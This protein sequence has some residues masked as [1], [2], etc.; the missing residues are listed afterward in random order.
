MA[1]GLP[2]HPSWREPYLKTSAAGVL[3]VQ[4]RT[5]SA[6]VRPVAGRTPKG[7][8]QPEVGWERGGEG[9]DAH[10]APAVDLDVSP[11]QQRVGTPGGEHQRT[12]TL[13]AACPSA[14][15]L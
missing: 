15:D 13:S 10:A 11:G 6:V 8:A 9:A 7:G 3:S 1:V 12:A 2:A 5:I 4:A 14:T